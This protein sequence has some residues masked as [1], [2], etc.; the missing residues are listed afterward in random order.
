MLVAVRKRKRKIVKREIL[1]PE[2]VSLLDKSCR[3]DA[4]PEIDRR[5]AKVKQILPEEKEAKIS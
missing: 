5:L 3:P 4:P 2:L 1:L